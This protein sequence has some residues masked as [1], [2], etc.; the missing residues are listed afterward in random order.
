ML[1]VAS[2]EHGLAD[3][4]VKGVGDDHRKRQTPG[5]MNSLLGKAA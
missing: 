2:N 3:E 5:I 1:F 4:W